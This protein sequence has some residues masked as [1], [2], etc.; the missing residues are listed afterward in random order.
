MEIE[1]D[2]SEREATITAEQR[3]KVAH[4]HGIPEAQYVAMPKGEEPG[5][6]HVRTLTAEERVA[7]QVGPDR[8]AQDLA[9][10]A[11]EDGYD[12]PV[13]G[14]NAPPPHPVW[15]ADP[16]QVLAFGRV[17]ADADLLEADTAAAAF[18][19][20]DKPFKWD[21][22]HAIWDV[23]GRPTSD[24]EQNWQWKRFLHGVEQ[25][26]TDQRTR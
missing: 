4:E 23:S 11:E 8:L 2:L 15:Y 19:Y 22:E 7:V 20:I 6:E 18:D 21:P 1:E 12:G 3:T 9:D 24:P 16:D 10:A 25:Y 17:L 26:Q 13:L 5:P 14:V